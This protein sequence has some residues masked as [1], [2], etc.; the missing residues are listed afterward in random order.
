MPPARG[1][2]STINPTMEGSEMPDCP[3]TIFQ[4]SGT[5]SD[6]DQA[7]VNAM[8]NAEKKC[9]ISAPPGCK[10]P[11]V[12]GRRE[13]FNEGIGWTIELDFQCQQGG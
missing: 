12:V 6:K 5:S 4:S 2:G 3:N 8:R 10:A 1:S 11:F 9:Q 7:E 13:H